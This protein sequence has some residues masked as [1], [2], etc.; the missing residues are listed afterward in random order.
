MKPHLQACWC[1][2]PEQNAEFVARMED[3][4][5]VYCLPYEP[6]RPVV[7]M[8]EKPKQ[9]VK[10]THQPLPNISGQPTRYDYE[11]ERNGVSNIF[12]FTEPLAGKRWVNVTE[13]RARRDWAYQIKEIADVRCPNAKLIR[14]VLDNLN[15]HTVGSLYET[16][17]PEEARRLAKR[18]EI[19]YTP[20]HGSWLNIAEVELSVLSRQCLNRRIPDIVTLSK[21]VN[22]WSEERNSAQTG[23][24]WQ[25]TTKDARI[26]LKRLYP[27]IKT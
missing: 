1:I 11:Y 8:D 21:E 10:E 27:E 9:L 6:D 23:V 17:E 24:D 18:L 3:V 26:K 13:H 15:T 22:N 7:C 12:L 16:F 2:P 4:L 5:D 20:K 25:F 14:L 19:H